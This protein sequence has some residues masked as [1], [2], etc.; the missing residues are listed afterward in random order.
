MGD[1]P[2]RFRTTLERGKE[3]MGWTV[4]RLPFD[5]HAVWTEMLRLRVRGEV[6]LQTASAWRFVL[7]YFLC[8]VRAGAICCW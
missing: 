8:R 4:A 1:K 2:K 7:R 6:S 5:P 3:G